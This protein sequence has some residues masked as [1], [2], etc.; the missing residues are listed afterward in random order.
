M[1]NVEF[2]ETTYYLIVGTRFS[3]TVCTI[4]IYLRYVE[5]FPEYDLQAFLTHYGNF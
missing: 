5:V 4:P 2:I 3:F 1:P